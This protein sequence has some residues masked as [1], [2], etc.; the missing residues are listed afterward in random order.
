MEN[1]G[2][3]YAWGD[4]IPASAGMTMFLSLA[5]FYCSRIFCHPGE[6]RDPSSLVER[7]TLT[8]KT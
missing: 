7:A 5:E 3:C 2:S 8:E 1:L 4:W 6:S